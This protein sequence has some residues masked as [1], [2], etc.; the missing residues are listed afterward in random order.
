MSRTPHGEWCHAVSEA[1]NWAGLTWGS[2]KAGVPSPTFCLSMPCHSRK[3][4]ERRWYRWDGSSIM[5]RETLSSRWSTE[6][7]VEH[8]VPGG[9]L[10]WTLRGGTRLWIDS[11]NLSQHMVSAK[12]EYAIALSHM[13]TLI[14]NWILNVSQRSCINNVLAT[15]L[16]Y[17]WEVDERWRVE[18]RRR[19]FSHPWRGYQDGLPF[20]SLYFLTTIRWAYLYCHMH[21]ASKVPYTE[22][23]TANN[24]FSL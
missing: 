17:C 1:L 16:W 14:L 4:Q 10:S 21:G 18:P 24:L 7:Q 9:A 13:D 20:F 19:N 23:M 3:L 8:W 11:R 2:H 12:L 5:W 6:S 22:T 15:S